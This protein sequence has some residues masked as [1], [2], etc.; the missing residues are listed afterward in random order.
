LVIE[1]DNGSVIGLEVKSSTSF[2]AN[3]FQGLKFLRDKLGSRF[4]G[5]VV[6][7]TGQRGYRFADKLFGL[8]TSALWEPLSKGVRAEGL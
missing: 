1:L 3:Q 7:N 6:L 5:G 8:P 2:N 4:L